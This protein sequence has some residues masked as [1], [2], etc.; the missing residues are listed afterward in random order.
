MHASLPAQLDPARG[1]D[2]NRVAETLL[3]QGGY[4][5]IV[6]MLGTTLLGVAAGVV[7]VPA[8]L[9]GRTLVCDTIAHSTLPGVAGAFLI[10]LAL[11]GDGRSMPAILA[12]GAIA[13]TFG[14]WL[15]HLLSR[16]TRLNEDAAIGVVLSVL[17]GLGV[18]LLSVVQK[19]E[20][21]GRAGLSGLIFGQAATLLRSD[22]ILIASVALPALLTLALLR[23]EVAMVCFD[24]QY[25]TV[26]G[27]PVRWIDLV[28]MAVIVLVTVAGLRTVGLLLIVAMLIIPAASARFW[29]DNLRHIAL[30]AGV[31]G[32]ISG[33][34]GSAISA[35]APDAPPGAVIV[36][37]GGAIFA[38]SL[39]LAP[40]RGILGSALRLAIMRARIASDH[41]LESLHEATESASR[42]GKPPRPGLREIPRSQR[43]VLRALTATG[44]V[45]RTSA[46]YTLTPKGAAEGARIR[47]NHS[48]WAAYLMRHADIAPSHVDWAVDRVEHVLDEAMIAQLEAELQAD[49]Q[50]G[51]RHTQTPEGPAP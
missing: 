38:L 6:V 31:I 33:Y 1:I 45:R 27:W 28:M 16:H 7:G 36:L 15:V 24:E 10:A 11:G 4:N 47:R 48:L 43:L 41:A 30:I 34:I 17:F 9:R 26:G 39:V 29:S 23:R 19:T 20:A 46:G 35:L 40:R 50:A 18:V 2:W 13:G 49:L 8:L 25:A 51:E 22:V 12:G 42:A 3:L 44:H 14:A 5:T 21:G 37:T 32:G